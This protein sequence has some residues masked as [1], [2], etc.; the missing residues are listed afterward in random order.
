[1][2]YPRDYLRGWNPFLISEEKDWTL[3]HSSDFPKDYS[4]GQFREYLQEMQFSQ[5]IERFYSAGYKSDTVLT[6]ILPFEIR[7]TLSITIFLYEKCVENRDFIRAFM[8]FHP[9]FLSRLR[10]LP[11]R[12]KKYTLFDWIQGFRQDLFTLLVRSYEREEWVPLISPIEEEAMVNYYAV[13]IYDIAVLEGYRP[14]YRILCT[15]VRLRNDIF[16]ARILLQVF[17]RKKDATEQPLI[18]AARN[19]SLPIFRL[20]MMY[21]ANIDDR[22]SEGDSVL[23][24][25]LEESPEKIMGTS[26]MSFVEEVLQYRPDVTSLLR[27]RKYPLIVALE[28]NFPPHIIVRLILLGSDVNF[29]SEDQMTPLRVLEEKVD[30]I[31][32]VNRSILRFYGA[33]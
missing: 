4:E 5:A 13:D 14:S 18:L 27:E 32:M 15:A 31:S 21:G 8:S 12:E 11:R 25:I 16:V 22:D 10:Y 20:L 17:P 2:R 19:F 24:V 29:V 9:P 1:M 23:E 3:M 28:G 7:R 33:R 30:A 26:L 6:P